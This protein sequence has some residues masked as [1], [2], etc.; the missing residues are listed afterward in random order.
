MNTKTSEGCSL[1]PALGAGRSA[2]TVGFMSLMLAACGGG[3]GGGSGGGS[4]ASTPPPV[5]G[6][7]DGGAGAGSGSSGGGSGDTSGGGSGG[8]TGGDSSGGSGGTLPRPVVYVADQDK[9]DIYE[10]YVTGATP[11]TSIKINAPLVTDGIV[12]V[13]EVMPDGNRVVYV[14]DQNILGRYE[15]FM[16]DLANPGA[17]VRLSA[18]LTPNRDV[19][20]FIVS[21]DGT[22]VVYRA[23]MD[24]DDVWELYVVDVA[25][26]GMATKV[27]APLTA[28]GWVRGGYL[29]SPDGTQIVY[30]ADQDVFENTELFLVNLATPGLSEQLNPALVSGGNVYESFKFS[31]DGAYVGYI[32]DQEVDQRL[33]LYVVPVTNPGNASKLNGPLVA[34]G[35]ICN[36]I[37]SPD[38]SRVAYCADQD[39]DGVHELYTVALNAPG[40]S[41]KLNP[42]LV[43]GGQVTAGY[44]FGPDS[45]YIVYAASED[46]AGRVDLYRVDIAAPG[47]ST[48]LNGTAGPNGDI[49]LFHISPDGARVAYMANQDSESVWELYE[50]SFADAG[51]PTKLSGPMLGEGLWWFDY[52]DDTHLVY[53]ADQDSTV[54]ELYRVDRT[55]PGVT[56][57]LNGNLVAGGEVWE[58]RIVPQG[59]S[60]T[61]SSGSSKLRIM[62]KPASRRST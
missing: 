62:T 57:R 37:F 59:S 30:R 49:P 47:A 20:D 55:A 40:V 16:A 48:K 6:S 31:P 7:T 9:Y 4:S 17:S 41:T 51:N 34:N 2:L 11:G 33:E 53:M 35:D 46:V 24:T 15:L 43:A 1:R 28:G 42:P 39:T 13:F 3:G 60:A 29:F 10:L 36:F 26:P 32:A 52:E 23:D 38:S 12:D 56:T 14:A 27:N 8:G 44:D 50:V 25:Q 45:D 19:K 22:K 58:Y 21:P 61:A 54:A 5:G 18:A